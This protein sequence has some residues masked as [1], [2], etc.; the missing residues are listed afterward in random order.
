VSAAAG[1][2][3]RTR[4]LKPRE[5]FEFLC[6]DFKTAWDA[7]AAQ[8][9]EPGAEGRG[10]FM[11]GLMAMVL[12]E[13]ACRLCAADQNKASAS[14]PRPVAV[15]DLG[16][17]LHRIRPSY[18]IPVVAKSKRL[19]GFVDGEWWLPPSPTAMPTKRGPWC[20]LLWLLWDAI[21]NGQAHQYQQIVAKQSDT[22][23]YIALDGANYGKTLQTI[24]ADPL[25]HADHLAPDPIQYLGA[26]GI[27]V[28]PEFL[29]LDVRQ[30]VIDANLLGRKLKPKPLARHYDGFTAR[31][32]WARL[33]HSP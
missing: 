27:R 23:L 32:L 24:A 13:W 19:S 20:P 8:P 25:H 29:Y 30:A 6:N 9:E 21:R 33:G 14:D 1:R 3:P 18:F 17:A 26:L 7:V 12:L 5:V 22:K 2:L 31:T 15:Y 10:N 11:F 16:R 4:N 28:H